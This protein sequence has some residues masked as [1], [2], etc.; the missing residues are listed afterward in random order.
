VVLVLDVVVANNGGHCPSSDQMAAHLRT[1]FRQPMPPRLDAP[2]ERE[3]G[4]LGEP[5]GMSLNDR[6]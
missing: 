3:D 5:S 4:R 1:G 2:N 6:R